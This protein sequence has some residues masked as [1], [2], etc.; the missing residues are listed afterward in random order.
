MQELKSNVALYIRLSLADKETGV[1]KNESNSI[2]GQR[3]YLQ[4]F[5]DVHE[6]LRNYGKIEY[7]DDGFSGTNDK[8]PKFQEMIADVKS[9]KV[10][11]ICVKDTSR[12]FRNYAEAGQYIDCVF[13][14]LGVRFLSIN[15]GYDSNDY[16][17]TTG[18]FEV[19]IKNIIY[20]AYSKDLSVK[21]SSA[22]THLIKQGKYMG[23]TPPYGYR[24]H[25][26]KPH[27]IVVDPIASENVKLVFA[28][29]L[30]GL[31]VSEIVG[32]CNEKSIISPGKYL[33][34]MYQNHE[35]YKSDHED[36]HWHYSSVYNLITNE[37][38]TGTMISKKRGK[39]NFYSKEKVAVEPLKI[40]NTHEAIVTKE[41][42]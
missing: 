18:G 35:R 1:S 24:M 17:G 11:A 30:E 6:E 34:G 28:Y 15:D 42:F 8:R 19:A 5:I 3:S 39:L 14:F 36:T 20:S 22:M 41:E 7:V 27:T 26:R 9:G 12:F 23:S 2:V 25:E 16:K 13:P 40:E 21:V 32:K 38:Y 33:R 29:A 4:Q 10:Q 37:M 31:T